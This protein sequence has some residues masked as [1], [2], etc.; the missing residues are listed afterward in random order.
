ML[1]QHVRP[2]WQRQHL[3]ASSSFLSLD[4][5]RELASSLQ[6]AHVW[7]HQSLL[8]GLQKQQ[9]LEDHEGQRLESQLQLQVPCRATLLR[10]NAGASFLQ[11][12]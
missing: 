5:Q 3:Q 7:L 6:Q 12:G 4:E 10:A 8:A 11:S 9:C 2:M 1:E